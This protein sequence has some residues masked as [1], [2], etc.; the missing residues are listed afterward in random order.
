MNLVRD[1]QHVAVGEP[2]LDRVAVEQRG[3]CRA[4]HDEGKLPGDVGGIHE[5]CVQSFAAQRA[6]QMGGIAQQEPPPVAQALDHALVHLEGR[7]PAEIAQ[8]HLDAGPRIEQRAQLGGRRKHVADIGLVAIDENQPAV[9]R[10]R[11]EQDES[12]RPDNE[13]TALRRASEA[14]FCVGDPVAAVV[15]LPGEMLLHRMARYAV[16]TARARARRPS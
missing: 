5:R 11:R 4:T 10:Q 12:G 9:V 6:G 7:H 14:N 2:A 13:A 15:S 16:T 8:P 3:L 1:F